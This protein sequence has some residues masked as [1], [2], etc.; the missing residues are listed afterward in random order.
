MK[1]FW[2]IAVIFDILYLIGLMA[3]VGYSDLTLF[4]IRIV[5]VVS[6][7]A[8][9]GL[10]VLLSLWVTGN[11]D[12]Y[13]LIGYWFVNLFVFVPLITLII[14]TSLVVAAIT[15]VCIND[16]GFVTVALYNMVT[17]GWLAGLLASKPKDKTKE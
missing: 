9:N 14:D 13:R 15:G 12:I 6:F 17:F 8:S 4:T 2:I 7:L 1:K 10:I 11:L 3:F 5:V 16:I